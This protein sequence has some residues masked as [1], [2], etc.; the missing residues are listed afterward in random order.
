[1][2][3]VLMVVLMIWGLQSPLK[4]PVRLLLLRL[5]RPLLWLRLHLLRLRFLR[6][7]IRWGLQD[8]RGRG[9]RETP[10]NSL[11]RLFQEFGEHGQ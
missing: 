7:K 6:C 9:G 2:K 8:G 5:L 4:V 1:M 10:R 11:G 3:F